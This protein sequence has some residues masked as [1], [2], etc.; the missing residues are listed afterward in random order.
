MRR[1]LKKLIKDKSCNLGIKLFFLLLI[2]TFVFLLFTFHSSPPQIPL[3]YSRPWG[4][5]QLS[6]AAVLFV[7]PLGVLLVGFIN[8]G[9]AGFLFE[10]FPFLARI[11]VWSTNLISLLASITTFKIITLVS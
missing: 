6:T 4:E 3:F 7:L 11:L 8:I 1:S 5:E 2:F 10:E 9:V